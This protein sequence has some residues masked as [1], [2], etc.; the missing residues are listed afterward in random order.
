VLLC[1]KRATQSGANARKISS[2][3]QCRFVPVPACR[4]LCVCVFVCVCVC[5][6]V[7]PHMCASAHACVRT[8]VSGGGVRGCDCL[9]AL[10]KHGV[11]RY[12]TFDGVVVLDMRSDG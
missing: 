1:R 8:C 4:V 7:Y 6:C 9:R 3:F 2:A 12:V 11:E 5:V 10:Q